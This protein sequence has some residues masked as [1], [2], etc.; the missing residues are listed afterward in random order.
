VVSRDTE[1]PITNGLPTRWL[2]ARDELYDSLRGPAKNFTLLAT[3]Y[4]E[5]SKEHEPMLL[6]IAYGKGRVFHTPMG[7]VSPTDSIRCVGFQTVFVRGTEWAATGK[8]TTAVPA[9]FPAADRVS[10]ADPE[11][12]VWKTLI[13]FTAGSCC[14]KAQKIGRDCA[15]PCCRKALAAGKVCSGCN[16]KS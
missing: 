11:D 3:A 10:I 4:S 7:H 2:H 9:N 1:H 5:K 13:R 14:D 12:V 6:T 15:H 16:A 8:V